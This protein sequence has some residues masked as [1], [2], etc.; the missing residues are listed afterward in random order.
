MDLSPVTLVGQH[1][2]LEP[3]SHTHTTDLLQVAFDPAIWQFTT[4]RI[5]TPADLTTYVET[6]LTWQREGHALPFATI[7]RASGRAIGSTRFAAIDVANRRAEIGWT[8]LGTAYQRTALN[9]EAK[10]LMLTHAFERLGC[11]RVELKTDVLNVRSRAA[12]RRLGATEEG[13][14]RHH[15][16]MPGGR[17]RDSVYFSLLA[18]EWPAAKAA[19]NEKLTRPR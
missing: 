18:D 3:L 15:M 4:A 6:A 1:A 9:T 12:I 2:R 17:L 7:D 16:I 13:I 14:L 5:T 19:L 8:W 11:I 10:L